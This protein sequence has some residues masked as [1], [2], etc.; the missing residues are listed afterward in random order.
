MEQPEI[1][2]WP[3]YHLILT[4]FHVFLDFLTIS[5]SFVLAYY[6]W[7]I[8]GPLLSVDMYE[9]VHYQRYSL[10]FG[11]SLISLL[12]GFEVM[13][14][15]HPQRSM[16]NIK[17]FQA[18]VKTWFMA[19]CV[20]M[21][22]LFLA[23]DLFFS[24]GIFIIA[25]ILILI[26]L[27]IE[28]YSFFKFNSR[29]AKMGVAHT[30]ILIYGSGIVARQL[31]YKFSKTPKLGYYIHGYIT[32]PIENGNHLAEPIL[33]EGE[34]LEQIINSTQAE[35]LFIAVPN[36]SSEKVMSILSICQKTGCQ[37]QV[38]PSLLDL[39][40][41]RVKLQ[42]LEGIPLLAIRQMRFSLSQRFYKR[43]LDI[44]L[45]LIL[46]IIFAPLIFLIALGTFVTGNKL[47]FEKISGVGRNLKKF[48]TYNLVYLYKA[49][50]HGKSSRLQRFLSASGLTKYPQLLSVL[51]GSLSL[52]GPKIETE[53][54]YEDLNELKKLKLNIKPGLIGLWN[55][56]SS[57]SVL[58]FPDDDMD[59]FYLQNQNFFLDLL[60]ISKVSWLFLFYG[61]YAFVKN[62]K[63]KSLLTQQ[64]KV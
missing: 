3:H 36:L 6:L 55:I 30:G 58:K 7:D 2:K 50:S 61:L 34:N 10:L 53:E 64:A 22:V 24:R 47:V 17:E 37:F 14:L 59:V 63:P 44:G 42:D 11:V 41:S 46:L 38:V 43:C 54:S 32:D 18:L 49:S 16:L 39:T 4:I 25:W 45:G 52:V 33:G 35:K 31:A 57:A 27:L 26:F 62:K 9:K 40:L 51:N 56:S 23:D 8:L 48:T 29:L 15:Y 13:D 19:C 1:K 28:R 21:I 12:I 20:T 60:V 5:L